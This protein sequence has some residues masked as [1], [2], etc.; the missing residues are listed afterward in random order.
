MESQALNAEAHQDPEMASI[1]LYP[2]VLQCKVQV[3]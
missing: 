2:K 1:P 3:M